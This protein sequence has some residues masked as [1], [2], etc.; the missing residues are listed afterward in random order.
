MAVF[1]GIWSAPE[2]LKKG[3][4][5][6]ATYAAVKSS[7]RYMLNI[8]KLPVWQFSGKYVMRESKSTKNYLDFYLTYL[9]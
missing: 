5:V 1:R 9:A 7:I 8:S 6:Y 2:P 4:G 3:S